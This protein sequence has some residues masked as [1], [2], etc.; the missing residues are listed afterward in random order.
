MTDPLSSFAGRY[1]ILDK[2]QEGGMGAIYKARHR[3]LDSIRVLKVMRPQLEASPELRERFLREAR[4]AIQLRHPNIAEV[5]DFAIDDSG[6]SCIV[7]EYIEGLNLRQLLRVA[8]APPVALAVEVARQGLK[9]LQYLHDRGFVHR[10]I[11]PDNLMLT[12]DV[13]GRPLVKLIDLGIA[14]HQGDERRLTST[15]VFMGKV[16]YAAPE[17]FAGAGTSGITSRSDLYSFGALLYELLTG[18][19]PIDGPD[20]SSLVSGHLF[21]PPRTFVDTDPT[22]RIDPAVR[23]V[24]L[25]ALAKSPGERFASANAMRD[26]LEGAAATGTAPFAER[27]AEEFAALRARLAAAGYPLVW[28]PSPPARDER[29]V[30][31]ETFEIPPTLVG[32]AASLPP[33]QAGGSRLDPFAAG[34]TPSTGASSI[35]PWAAPPSTTSAAPRRR[36]ALW[37]AV[38]ATV[39]LAIA[40]AVALSLRWLRPAAARNVPGSALVAPAG[41]GVLL[42]DASPWGEV[43]EVREAGGEALALGEDRATPLRLTLPAAHYVVRVRHPESGEVRTLEVDVAGDPAAPARVAT[44][45]VAAPTD[46]FLAGLP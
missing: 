28:S 46:L 43:L 40:G 9:A 11:S 10:D 8:G 1:E 3:L 33:T 16:L 45:F 7:M 32:G 44:S 29:A 4:A 30:R 15:G 41:R 37:I 18:A 5:V 6:V 21:R 27:L 25:R 42:I 14:K 17:Q 20:V 36:P 12:V 24:V 22:G 19:L 31:T 34:T 23:E 2:L 39:A 35:S 13:E 26:A 38:T